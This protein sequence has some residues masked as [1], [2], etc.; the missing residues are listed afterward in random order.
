[1]TIIT[2]KPEYTFFALAQQKVIALVAQTFTNSKLSPRQKKWT[3]R[4]FR[5]RST[6]NG[7]GKNYGQGENYDR[8]K[9]IIEK[10]LRKFWFQC[11]SH[12][13]TQRSSIKIALMLPSA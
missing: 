6:Y 5:S 4:H 2:Y 7:L 12:Y 11:E 1:M 13:V 9:S 10:Y 8:A 3:G